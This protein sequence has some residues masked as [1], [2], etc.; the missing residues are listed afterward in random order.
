MVD[1]GQHAAIIERK[2]VRRH[3]YNTEMDDSY[4]KRA[5]DPYL[6]QKKK[7]WE[8]NPELDNLKHVYVNGAPGS[9]KSFMCD[10]FYDTLDIG[11]RKKRMHFSEFM[12]QVHEMEHTVN[13]K[14]KGKTGET[15]AIVGN[16]LA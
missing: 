12:L 13:Q 9:G 11:T 15:I 16:Q 2:G 1:L 10:M 5:M 6:R 14:L 8:L 7:I 3:E 4:G